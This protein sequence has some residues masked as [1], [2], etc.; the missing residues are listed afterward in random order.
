MYLLFNKQVSHNF[1]TIRNVGFFDKIQMIVKKV[2][3]MQIM[4]YPSE[5]L[6]DV[7]Y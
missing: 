6:E 7:I 2:N 1:R 5:V 4:H 3:L